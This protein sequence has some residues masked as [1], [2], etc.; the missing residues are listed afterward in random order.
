MA[1][2]RERH[3]RNLNAAL[4]RHKVLLNEMNHRVKNSLAI[5]GS[6]LHLQASET[7]NP[8]LTV[9]LTEAAHRVTAIAS[10]HDLLYQG[11]EVEWL[12]VGK[13]IA[14]VCENLNAS[15]S[16][17]EVHC[18]ADLGIEIATDRAIAS[19]L[20][21]NELV[22][23]ACKYAYPGRSGEIWVTLAKDGDDGFSIS[24][25]DE[26][27]GL[28]PES[29][30]PKRKGLGMRLVRAFAQ[31]LSGSVEIKDAAPGVEFI[32]KAPR[33]SRPPEIE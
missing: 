12:D 32:I 24:V 9:H 23:N 27:V 4:E 19:A 7:N 28:A 6:I 10:A 29:E 3:E 21:V 15:I 1:I 30:P 33:N 18:G 22:A 5:V 26:G 16:S 17:C 20:V 13:Y 31:Q 11:A 8:E 2:E 25:R 14:S